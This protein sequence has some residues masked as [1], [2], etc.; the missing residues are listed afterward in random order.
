VPGGVALV[1][2]GGRGIGRAT[3]LLLAREGW[4]VAISARS[5]DQLAET[6]KL[7]KSPILAV[8][9][10]VADP[11]AVS[12]LARDVEGQLGPIDLLVNNAGTAGPL[13]AFWE[14]DPA[15][16]WRCQEVNLRGPMMCCRA[17]LPGMI[18]RRAGRIVNI[19]S[20]AGCHPLENMSAYVTS[21]TSLI[22]FTEQLAGE[23]EGLGVNVFSVRP[24]VIR[25]AMAEEARR[26]VRRI[27]Q[28]LDE[29]A[30]VTPQ[31]VAG[32]VLK[33]A[34]GEADKL[35]GRMFAVQDDVD[36]ILRQAE[37]VRARELYLLRMFQL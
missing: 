23:L 9:G 25:T 20:G 31:A 16:W 34:S 14:T 3:A 37:D 21:K 36:A 1:T 8:A 30:E 35:S 27:Q 12:T 24:G 7:A 5:A 33:L 13:G 28:L 2:G 32:L 26:Y 15:E 10:D 11:A 18:A 4:R 19:A 6:V 29:G 17:L 22:R